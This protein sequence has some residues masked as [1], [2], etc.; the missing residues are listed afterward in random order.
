MARWGGGPSLRNTK[1]EAPTAAWPPA[2][3][4]AA[5]SARRAGSAEGRGAT[6]RPGTRYHARAART[7]PWA[8][9][10]ESPTAASS[11]AGR[12]DRRGRG[13]GRGGSVCVQTLP[14]RAPPLPGRAAKRALS[15]HLFRRLSRWRATREGRRG[16]GGG[17][18]EGGNTPGRVSSA[19]PRYENARTRATLLFRLLPAFQ[20]QLGLALRVVHKP[21]A[22]PTPAPT[23]PFSNSSETPPPRQHTSRCTQPLPLTLCPRPHTPRHHATPTPAN[24]PDSHLRVTRPELGWTKLGV[25]R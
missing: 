19:A 18:G 25:A 3:H 16:R 5:S 15:A 22:R 4:A 7:S 8:G 20:R 12:A 17:G 6:W 2:T 11:S 14:G 23:A 13:A 10:H 21:V 9:R 1:R 24:S